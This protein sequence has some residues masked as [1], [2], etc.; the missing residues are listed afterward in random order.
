MD[1]TLFAE[2]VESMQLHNEIIAG[3]S[4]VRDPQNPWQPGSN[5]NTYGLLRQHFSKGTDLSLHPQAKLNAAARQ[6]N[7]PPRKTLN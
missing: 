7:E 4:Q 2:L 5:E 1:K 3:Y 6:L